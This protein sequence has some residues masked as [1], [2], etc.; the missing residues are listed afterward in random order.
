IDS[1]CRSFTA[2]SV[3]RRTLASLL[4]PASNPAWR[5]YPATYRLPLSQTQ[6]RCEGVGERIDRAASLRSLATGFPALGTPADSPTK[7]K[8]MKGDD[9]GYASEARRPVE[10]GDR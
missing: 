6:L 3:N 2:R 5:N 8:T 9:H 10:V 1:S 4:A 7:G